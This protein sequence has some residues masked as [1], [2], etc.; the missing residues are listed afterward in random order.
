MYHYQKIV[1]G[2]IVS[3]FFNHCYNAVCE[4]RLEIDNHQRNG[5]TLDNPLKPS[6][7]RYTGRTASGD[8]VTWEV[9]HFTPED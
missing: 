4:M 1:N 6:I 5:G 3:R 9:I 7:Y 2:A 8:S